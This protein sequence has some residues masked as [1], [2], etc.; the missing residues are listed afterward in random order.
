MLEAR[1]S[2]YSAIAPNQADERLKRIKE[3]ALNAE[4]EMQRK[5]MEE[6]SRLMK[7][8]EEKRQ[9]DLL[10]AEAI[11]LKDEQDRIRRQ[12]EDDEKAR[13]AELML[14][15]ETKQ[16]MQDEADYGS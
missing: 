12:Q 5:R 10:A 1:A 11:R 2:K 15:E 6:E 4:A 14:Q 8:E 13:Q 3:E 9:A 7:L 16:A